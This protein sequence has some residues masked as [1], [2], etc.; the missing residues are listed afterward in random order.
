MA[1]AGWHRGRM[2]CAPKSGAMKVALALRLRDETPMTQQWI[3]N[4]LDTGSA[5][6]ISQLTAKTK[7]CRL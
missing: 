3:T 5:S 4:R 6:C 7:E 1:V 2:E